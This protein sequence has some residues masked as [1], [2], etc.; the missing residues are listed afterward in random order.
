M[1]ARRSTKS[2][3]VC[4]GA[5][6]YCIAGAGE[7]GWTGAGATCDEGMVL[8]VFIGK[9]GNPLVAHCV[10]QWVT[11]CNNMLAP[12]RLLNNVVTHVGFEIFGRRCK[13]ILV[14]QFVIAL[15]A[16]PIQ[17]RLVILHNYIPVIISTATLALHVFI[18][19]F[20]H[21][22]PIYTI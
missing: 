13:F 16:P 12:F 8:G 10:Q 18:F 3:F 21:C 1:V 20:C 7:E 19:Y 11:P 14:P 17:F 22:F 5:C 4:V 6:C 9:E 2:W 15:I